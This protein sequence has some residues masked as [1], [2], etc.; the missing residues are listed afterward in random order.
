MKFQDDRLAL[1]HIPLDIYPFF[2]QPILQLLFHEIP[3][4]T[5][6]TTTTTEG[7]GEESKLE[8][9]ASEPNQPAF[10]NIS[11]TPVECSIVCSRELADLYLA[12]LAIKFNESAPDNGSHVSISKDDFIV[13]QVDG[14]G[15]DAG[16]RVME[17][18]SPLAMAGM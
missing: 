12:P 18:T 2:L 8:D 10:L 11:I 4:I 13:M 5:T 1:V 6:T 9:D 7:H 17:L 16:Q 3:P 14:Q 15:L